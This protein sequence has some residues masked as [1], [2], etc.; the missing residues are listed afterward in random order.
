MSATKNKQEQEIR[1]EEKKKTEKDYLAIFDT[2]YKE[3]NVVDAYHDLFESIEL[4]GRSY[5]VG[6]IHKPIMKVEIKAC[7][8]CKHPIKSYDYHRNEV[9]C[10]KCGVVVSTYT[11]DPGDYNPNE[12]PW[13]DGRLRKD[14]LRVIGLERKRKRKIEGFNPENKVKH[15]SDM[16]RW[17][18]K[19]YINKLDL[20]AEQLKMTEN[21]K[22]IVE[23]VID[24]YNLKQIHSRL[25]YDTIIPAICRYVLCKNGKGSELRFNRAVFKENNVTPENYELMA[26]NIKRL[27]IFGH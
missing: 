13:N 24:T 3:F 11:Y 15:Q 9:V 19:Q 18:R 27:R 1:V 22:E 21:E 6:R 20:V 4:T 7:P 16:K 23:H 17:R 8:V 25:K 5:T 12:L 2:Y 14:E 26:N 10:D